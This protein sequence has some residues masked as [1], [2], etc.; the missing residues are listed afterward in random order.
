MIA[1]SHIQCIDFNL[2]DVNDYIIPA[3]SLN[4]VFESLD[5]EFTVQSKSMDGDSVT[6][7]QETVKLYS[8]IN[9]SPSH[10]EYTTSQTLSSTQNTTSEVVD[11]NGTKEPINSS[12]TESLEVVNEVSSE[13]GTT[14][15]HPT[16]AGEH[17]QTDV[18]SYS[19]LQGSIT[20]DT[21]C[22]HVSPCDN[23]LTS[24]D[25][26]L[27]HLSHRTEKSH[28]VLG[29]NTPSLELGQFVPDTGVLGTGY[30]E[31]QGMYSRASSST[32]NQSATCC[33]AEL[34][35]ETNVSME[36]SAASN[37]YEP[38]GCSTVRRSHG[39]EA[40]AHICF[41]L[42]VIEEDETDM[43][44]SNL[45][46]HSELSPEQKL[47]TWGC[48]TSPNYIQDRGTVCNAH[49]LS[50]CHDV[51]GSN[52]TDTPVDTLWDIEFSICTPTS[53]TSLDD[54]F[55][56]TFIP[57]THDALAS[58]ERQHSGDSGI[59]QLSTNSG[60]TERVPTAM[61]NGYVSHSSVSSADQDATYMHSG[62]SDERSSPPKRSSIPICR[63]TS[64]DSGYLNGDELFTH[65]LSDSTSTTHAVLSTT[66]EGPINQPMH[67]GEERTPL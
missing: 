44:N 21:V 17:E 5:I 1:C 28:L 8:T 63:V 29:Q 60:S 16:G 57:M 27:L 39:S 38:T 46:H 65:L 64:T 3:E 34:P 33:A 47:A 35:T 50:D 61:L 41:T 25:A 4:S 7:A 15:D 30:V 66:A 20:S 12:V 56:D 13:V 24:C 58:V 45:V 14:E 52:V 49:R 53:S 32:S 40:S 19:S 22:K 9:P 62:D 36:G 55:L 48:T 18:R 51:G 11:S 31:D 42:P 43:G 26:A 2:V 54:V 37:G 59:S 23:N 6:V 10:C 67:S